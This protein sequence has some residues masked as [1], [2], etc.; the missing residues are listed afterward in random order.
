MLSLFKKR[1]KVWW[2]QAFLTFI[3]S[4]FLSVSY[5][6]FVKQHVSFSLIFLADFFGYL[7]IVV[8]LLLR[9]HLQFRSNIMLGFILIA[10]AMLS[11][12]LPVTAS[13]IVFPY[14]ILTGLGIIL[15]FCPYN[16]LY[17]KELNKGNL[18]HMTF[19]WAIGVF[20]GIV[21]PIVGGFI[22][23][24]FKLPIFISV[25]CAVLFLAIY[26][27]RLVE[28]GE[29]RYSLSDAL[30]HVKG[31]RTSMIVDGALHKM[32][33]II[34]TVFSLRYLKTEIN[35]GLF[36]S[37][38]ALMGIFVA[39]PVARASDRTKK[40]IFLIW[41]LSLLSAVLVL[42]FI[43]VDN[44]WSYAILA[45]CLKAV[46]S[47]N[48]PVR[49]NV[50]LDKMEAKNP[51]AWISR[52]LYLNIGRLLLLAATSWLVYF[53]YFNAVF[54]IIACLHFVYPILIHYKK[55]YYVAVN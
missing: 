33:F 12:F 37:V 14:T 49:A 45:L 22:L 11:L 36:L 52:E 34:V 30:R 53:N 48:D 38:A 4:G 24:T 19:Y 31:L 32:A 27:T 7:T 54:V 42:L 25:A 35:F 50:I 10:L 44:F 17:F 15:F 47:I 28:K 51:I 21:A 43:L 23:G 46:S 20:M 3:T 41:F 55:V 39:F 9:R 1:F 13:I 8:Y 5:I 18:Q 26:T 29:C 16:I 6:Y 40:R 2:L